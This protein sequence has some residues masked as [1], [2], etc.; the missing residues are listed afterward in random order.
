M[1]SPGDTRPRVDEAAGVVPISATNSTPDPRASE[2]TAKAL[3]KQ[4]V[5][6]AVAPRM[7]SMTTGS[8]GT[9][10]RQRRPSRRVVEG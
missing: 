10:H 3:I 5:T 7:S 9:T 8:M 6:A 4:R 1:W 2:V